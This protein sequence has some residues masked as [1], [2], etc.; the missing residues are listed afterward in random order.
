MRTSNG[1]TPSAWLICVMEQ[2]LH[3]PPGADSS[4][5]AAFWSEAEPGTNRCAAAGLRE[6][7]RWRHAAWRDRICL[8]RSRGL[9]EYSSDQERRRRALAIASVNVSRSSGATGIGVV[10][11][12]AE[13]P[14]MRIVRTRSQ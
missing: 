14:S 9:A 6:K 5:A 3:V 4:D 8:K 11:P 10:G 2:A 12:F 7:R 13:M 1:S